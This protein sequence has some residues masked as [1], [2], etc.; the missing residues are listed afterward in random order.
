[1]CRFVFEVT[2]IIVYFTPSARVHFR[3]PREPPTAKTIQSSSAASAGKM[4]L[5]RSS[6]D[7]SRRSGRASF[8]RSDGP[9]TPH[10]IG[11]GGGRFKVWSWLGVGAVL[12]TMNLQ[13][14]R[15]P[16]P[17]PV[18]QYFRRRH[19]RSITW[20]AYI[21]IIYILY[22]AHITRIG[23]ILYFHHRYNTI[24]FAVRL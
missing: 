15:T 5:P 19:T 21:P 2:T 14:N 16:P 13:I 4:F 11:I 22:T 1:V 23:C 24:L 10:T 6:R 20:E 3:G 18:R 9:Q 7:V 17:P 12:Y 8:R